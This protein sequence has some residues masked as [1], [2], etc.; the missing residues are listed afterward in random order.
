MGDVGRWNGD[1]LQRA[2]S[3][4]EWN[5]KTCSRQKKDLPPL[6]HPQY[7]LP[8]EVPHLLRATY[9]M[10]SSPGAHGHLSFCRMPS[11]RFPHKWHELFRDILSAHLSVGNSVAV[12]NA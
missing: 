11:G 7:M 4:S 1:D 6:D 5:V 12:D 3:Y 10:S 8:P 9:L 2:E